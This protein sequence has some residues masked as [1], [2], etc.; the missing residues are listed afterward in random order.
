MVSLHSKFLAPARMAA[1]ALLKL[2]LGAGGAVF[3]N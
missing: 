2:P 3:L 1:N